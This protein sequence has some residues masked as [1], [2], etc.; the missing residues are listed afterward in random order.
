MALAFKSI[1][2]EY[3]EY[4]EYTEQYQKIT[5]MSPIPHGSSKKISKISFYIMLCVGLASSL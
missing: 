5:S 2:T 1:Y 4:I 3:T